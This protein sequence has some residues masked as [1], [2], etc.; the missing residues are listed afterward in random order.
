MLITYTRVP[1]CG[2]SEPPSDYSER[3]EER[4]MNREEME[5]ASSSLARDSSVGSLF[6]EGGDLKNA[7]GVLSFGFSRF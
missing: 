1:N 2:D 3:R 6:F 5:S 4:M 7:L